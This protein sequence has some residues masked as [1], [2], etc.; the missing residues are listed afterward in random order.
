[1]DKLQK[2]GKQSCFYWL[3]LFAIYFFSIAIMSSFSAHCPL[4]FTDYMP[5]NLTFQ[6][7]FPLVSLL[8]LSHNGILQFTE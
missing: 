4:E 2:R 6:K 1:M 8:N 7:D 3:K 5:I